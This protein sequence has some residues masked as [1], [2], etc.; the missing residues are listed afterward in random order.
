MRVLQEW[1]FRG[2]LG[3]VLMCWAGCESYSFSGTHPDFKAMAEGSPF[4]LKTFG[5][6]C[7]PVYGLHRE[8]GSG[9]AGALLEKEDFE[10]ILK[11]RYPALLT[12]DK[13]ACPIDVTVAVRSWEKESSISDVL[14]L[15]SC[16]I[17]PHH[18]R[19]DDTCEVRVSVAG[20]EG[21]SCQTETVRTCS[22]R[23]WSLTPLGLLPP[24]S[25]AEGYSGE[26]RSGR[27]PNVTPGSDTTCKRDQR[28]VFCFEVAD[29]VAAAL[30]RIDPNE[31]K[32]ARVMYELH[33]GR[34]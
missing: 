11:A 31:L 3:S 9:Y 20:K 13:K 10:P 25:R 18:V 8:W 33:E 14:T 6:N 34:K 29:A 27:G 1:L 28:E 7:G 19:I 4:R 17:L 2:I 21:V 15:L 22:T 5:V 16:F 23:W 24:V 30:S 12:T 26:H 32:R